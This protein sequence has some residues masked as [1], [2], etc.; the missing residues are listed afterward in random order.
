M[1]RSEVAPHSIFHGWRR[2][3]GCITLVMACLLLGMSLRARLRVDEIKLSVPRR[4]Q[5]FIHILPSD[6]NI[7]VYYVPE[8]AR[9][10]GK[11]SFGE[12]FYWHSWDKVESGD[13][14]EEQETSIAPVLESVT[15]RVTQ[16]GPYYAEGYG[17]RLILPYWPTAIPLTFL[18]GYLI[19]CKPKPKEPRHA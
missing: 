2:K 1:M 5:V 13:Q 9:P 8:H 3:T 19:L 7:E 15:A 16:G 10:I 18:S 4:A 12:L 11:L 17:W 6:M 14:R